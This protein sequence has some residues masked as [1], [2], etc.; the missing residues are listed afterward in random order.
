[1][2]SKKEETSSI[3]EIYDRKYDSK[4]A[5]ISDTAISSVSDYLRD[6]QV[7]SDLGSP[8]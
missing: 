8:P 2:A 3:Y 4:Q 7:R 5:V 6:S 1:V